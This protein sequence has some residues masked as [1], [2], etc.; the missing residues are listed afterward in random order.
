M[1]QIYFLNKKQG[2]KLQPCF[3]ILNDRVEM[4]VRPISAV[5]IIR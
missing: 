3:F 5:T 1:I 4:G 2:R